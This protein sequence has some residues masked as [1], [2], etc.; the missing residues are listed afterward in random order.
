MADTKD[1]ILDAA[2]KLFAEQGFD[3]TSLREITAA[4]KV[5]LA[6]VNYHFQSKEA[7]IAAVV[8]RRMGPL[9]AAR[10]EALERL[11]NEA[12]G[13]PLGVEKI[14]E[15]FLLPVLAHPDIRRFKPLMA[16][17]YHESEARIRRNLLREVAPV[18]IRFGAALHRALP[19]IPMRE[20]HWRVQFAVGMMAYMLGAEALI[21]TM[22]GEFVDPGDF[23]AL[24]P[25]Y[26]AFAAAGMRAP[27]VKGRPRRVGSAPPGEE[28]ACRVRR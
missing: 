5:N 4:A 6:A 17:M 13:K 15:A 24:L 12:K 25:R 26:V 21:R 3:R 19:G 23:K 28:D 8:T 16:K 9:N 2:E 1:L 11:E 20:L 27:V 22:S 18:A 14:L 10:L 7:L